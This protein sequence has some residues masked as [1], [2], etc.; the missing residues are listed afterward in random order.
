MKKQSEFKQ[1]EQKL[2]MKMKQREM[3]NA[4]GPNGRPGNS[5]GIP[6]QKSRDTKPKGMASVSEIS[7]I[8]TY[9]KAKASSL[10][11]IN[12]IERIITVAI[13]NTRGKKY[14]KSLSKKDREGI[15]QISFAIA[16]NV[17]DLIPMDLEAA[18]DILRNY[19]SMQSRTATIYSQMLC[20][21]M[22]LQQRKSA[23][24]GAIATYDL[25]EMRYEMGV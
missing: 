12:N 13:L 4:K 3:K 15:E 6:Q 5:S 10:D 25:E 8:V 14:K 21:E 23:M 22:N 1:V 20:P 16:S 24:A 9:E 11:H 18:Q 2:M 17:D 19:P 7:W